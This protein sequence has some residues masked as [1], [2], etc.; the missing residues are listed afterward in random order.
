MSKTFSYEIKKELSEIN[1]LAKKNEVEYE[2]LGYL[3]SS[4][5]EMTKNRIKYATE[6][7]YNI[8]RF[9]KLLK[10]VNINDFKIE[11]QGKVYVIKSKIPE[12]SKKIEQADELEERA[13]VRGLFLGSGSINNPNN[14]YHLEVK[15]ENKE[16]IDDIIKILKEWD[17]NVKSIDKGIY[18]KDG[19][20]ISKFLAFIG[21][22]KS[23][24][25]F[26]EIRVQRE[27]N[28]KV[29]RIVNCKTA[30][31]N[32]TLNASV[33]QINAIKRLKENGK[34]KKLD[35]GLKELAELR[36]EYP[37]MPLS[38]L[39]KKLKNPI[40]KSG[41]NYRLKKIIELSK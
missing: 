27:M 9:G 14:K 18:I 12:L 35:E 8:N 24:L 39:G 6:N 22:N 17:I 4:N 32:K 1:N 25:E 38:E 13:F 26:E 2:L 10:N 23:V 20:E 40:G 3:A 34:F 29:N 41:V 16:L 33:E 36:L 30:N 5:I 11:L 31:L 19:E 37:D 21:A 7:E 28:N 15:I